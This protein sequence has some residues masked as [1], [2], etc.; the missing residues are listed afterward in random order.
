MWNL[1]GQGIELVFSALAGRLP[2]TGPP[3]K[4]AYIFLNYGLFYS[5]PRETIQYHSN[6]SLCPISNA[7]EAGVQQFY[8]DL[9]DLLELTPKKK[10]K[11]VVFIIGD[12]NAKVGSQEI[13][14][15]KRQICPWS[16]E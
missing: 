13:P 5:F 7:K 6:P 4:P 9:Q 2:T 10:K 12:W 3:G 11:K 8:E 14:G 1:P 15:S 16:T